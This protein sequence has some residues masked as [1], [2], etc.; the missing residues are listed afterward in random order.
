MRRLPLYPS[1]LNVGFFVILVLFIGIFCLR[2][3]L[4][5]QAI[6]IDHKCTDIS[7][8]PESWIKAAKNSLRCSYGH[9]SHGS[10]LITATN[11]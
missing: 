9:T 10:Q 11:C 6:N 3:P 2:I 7:L 5:S 1:K 8:V 4:Y